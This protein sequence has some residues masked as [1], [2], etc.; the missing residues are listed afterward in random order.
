MNN[1]VNNNEGDNSFCLFNE[2]KNN[3]NYTNGKDNKIDTNFGF[4]VID[5]NTFYDILTMK[6]N[7]NITKK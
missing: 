3:E 1:I 6:N 5:E 7:I 2:N 4:E